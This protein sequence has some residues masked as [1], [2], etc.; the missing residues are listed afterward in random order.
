[1]NELTVLANLLRD[2]AVFAANEVLVDP[3]IGE[4]ALLPLNRMLAFQG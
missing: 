4:R 1:M 2:D 3:E